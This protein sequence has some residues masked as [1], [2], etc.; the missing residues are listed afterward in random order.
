M[1]HRRALCSVLAAVVALCVTALLTL[2]YATGLEPR[3]VAVRTVRLAEPPS[4]GRYVRGLYQTPA[5]PL[6][7]NPGLGTFLLRI[8]FACRPEI[9][10]IER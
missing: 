2:A 6:Y 3:W 4:L 5:G 10:V 7:V 9:T 1:V 8:R